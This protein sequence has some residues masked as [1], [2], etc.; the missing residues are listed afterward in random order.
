[1]CVV[2]YHDGKTAFLD[3]FP[4]NRFHISVEDPDGITAETQIEAGYFKI[5][6]DSILNFFTNDILPF[7][8]EE[9]MEVI[10][11]RDALL[12][13]ENHPDT[14]IRIKGRLL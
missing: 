4:K 7:P 8:K 6:L 5:M 3:Y 1:M 10:A 14:W 9:T 2:K 11:I 12:E 13:G